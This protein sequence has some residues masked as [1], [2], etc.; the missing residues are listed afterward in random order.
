MLG[1]NVGRNGGE[2]G[3]GEEGGRLRGIYG[4]GKRKLSRN[5]ERRVGEEGEVRK[6]RRETERD[7]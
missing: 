7:I 1:W 6:G 2:G 5:V 4:E 3:S